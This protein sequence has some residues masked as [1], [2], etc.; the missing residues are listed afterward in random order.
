M[1]DKINT[2]CILCKEIRPVNDM[3]FVEPVDGENTDAVYLRGYICENC[4]IIHW[5]YGVPEL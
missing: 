1:T 3:V 5:A 2:R 4:E